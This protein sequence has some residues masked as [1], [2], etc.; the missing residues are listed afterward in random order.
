MFH[1][2]AE[3]S[4]RT[5]QFPSK[6]LSSLFLGGTISPFRSPNGSHRSNVFWT[7]RGLGVRKYFKYELWNCSKQREVKWDFYWHF[8]VNDGKGKVLGLDSG[9]DLDLGLG[10]RLFEIDLLA[11]SHLWQDEL[12]NQGEYKYYLGV[13][14]CT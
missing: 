6:R 3:G 1:V 8:H 9:T 13:Y 11:R 14:V 10:F 12:Q 4:P 7:E 5:T 2:P